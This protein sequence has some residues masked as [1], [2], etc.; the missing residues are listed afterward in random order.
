VR[1]HGATPSS[2]IEMYRSGA[3]QGTPV[4]LVSGFIGVASFWEGFAAHVAPTRPVV[5]YDQR[6]TGA[7]GAFDLPLTLEQM[8]EDAERV[9]DALGG[10]PVHLVGHSAGAGVGL[11]V[12]ARQPALTLVAGWTRADP[13]MRRVFEA[14]L[15]ALRLAGPHGY[16][17]LTT[18]FMIPPGDVSGRDEGI[19]VEEARSAAHLP[20]Y[21]ELGA[22][23]D[24]VLAFEAERWLPRVRCPTLVLGAEDDMMTPISFSIELA[25]RIPGARLHRLP[26]GG[27]YCV[28]TRPE[29]TAQALLH[30]LDDQ[31]AT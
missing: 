16:A 28:R 27:H 24:A 20:S 1:V 25:R 8:A 3:V 29:A 13:W 2:W 15:H 5:S 4:L 26:G 7:S 9:I 22:R 10:G 17:R 6:G 31:E 18:L 11:I 12:A 14:R 23:A 21:E 30:F 19:A